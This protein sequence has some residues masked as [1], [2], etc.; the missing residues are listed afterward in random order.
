MIKKSIIK[1]YF[2]ASISFG[3][4][5]GLIFPFYTIF[6]VTF[7]SEIYKFVYVAGCIIAGIIVGAFSFFIGNITIIRFL[8]KISNQLNNIANKEADLTERLDITSNDEVGLL[9][10][11]FNS[12]VLTL[13][14]IVKEIKASIKESR[15]V[16]LNLASTSEESSDYIGEIKSGIEVIKEKA[17]ISDVEISKS[18]EFSAE[19]NSFTLE[20]IDLIKN[21]SSNINESSDY[22]KE[23]ASSI[24]DISETTQE[25]MELVD[26][27]KSIARSGE[28]EMQET[29]TTINKIAEST[30]VIMDMMKVINN[31]ASQ[32]NL[33]AMNAAIEAAHAGE[34][35]KG[36]AVVA[37]EIRKLA[38]TTSNNS[39]EISSS[40]KNIIEYINHSDRLSSNTGEYFKN[41]LTGIIEVADSIMEIKNTMMDLSSESNHMMNNLSSIIN[42]NNSVKDSSDQMLEK[43][44]Y[45]KTS[46]EKI[47]STS[48]NT[49]VGIDKIVLQVD[50]LYELVQTVSANGELN[51]QNVN[52]IEELLKKFQTE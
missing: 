25:K 49:K 52:S 47:D 14:N 37:D 32:T 16:G 51:M 8:K 28:S 4:L 13:N 42:S 24:Q 12:F 23:M 33:L 39:R 44:K 10:K 5:M 26:N 6:F 1:K 15:N 36:F 27:L 35:G 21:Q 31:I 34:S 19:L 20:F 29:L 41:I 30:H 11:N 17:D 38:E 18:M 40:L 45:I 46:L 43:I 7:K 2:F 9:A 22:I 48:G 3:V 50:K